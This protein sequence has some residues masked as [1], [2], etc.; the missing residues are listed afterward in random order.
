[1]ATPYNKIYDRAMFR[2]R[3]YEFLRL[4]EYDRELVLENHLKS[5]E[6]D[7]IDICRYDLTKI[8]DTLKEYE[9]DLDNETI[10]VLAAGV[11]YYWMSSKV[12]SEE[13]FQNNLSLKE[14]T[15][16]SP[17]NLLRE[18]TVL[19][20]DLRKEFNRKMIRYSYTGSKL[21]EWRA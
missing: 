21:N 4:T 17:A 12:L 2:F 1:M 20:K 6:A 9:E 11:A 8:N 14:Y 7:F 18:L 16:H 5:A 19:R 13:L 3:D 10:D 15:I